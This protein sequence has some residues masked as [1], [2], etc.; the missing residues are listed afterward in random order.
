[1][2]LFMIVFALLIKSCHVVSQVQ[3]AWTN[4]SLCSGSN[5]SAVAG[6][7]FPSSS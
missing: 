5:T 6:K 2:H 1:M 7:N 4:V 3:S